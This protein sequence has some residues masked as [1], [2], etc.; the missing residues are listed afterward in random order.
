MDTH[1]LAYL[2]GSLDADGSFGMKRSTY[3]QR[4]RGD[5]NNPVYS[6]RVALRQVTPQVPELLKAA[7]GGN[8]RRDKP[9]TPNSRS[10]YHWMISD[11]NASNACE[12]LLPYLRIKHRQARIILELRESKAPGYRS[13]AYWFER[14]YPDWPD[15]ELINTQEAQQIL[16]YAN[17]GSVS[18]AI[19]NGLLLA[20]PHDN[21]ATMRPRICK[22]LV[23]LVAENQRTAGNAPSRPPALIAW[24]E[25]LYQEIRELNKVGVNGTPL[26]HK[27][28]FYTPA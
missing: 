22:A 8:L 12:L 27:T 24:R 16:G 4:V 14:E 6:E 5:S 9:Q 13:Y 1:L 3:H 11:L 2:A 17:R 26:Y 20:L 7:F 28:G 19:S 10:G 18:Q 25:R 21:V 15:M 23:E